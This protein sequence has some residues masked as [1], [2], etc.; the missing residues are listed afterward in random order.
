MR[1]L[2][3]YI[4]EVSPKL[5]HVAEIAASLAQREPLDR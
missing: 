5:Q 2:E 4:T 1:W 3:R